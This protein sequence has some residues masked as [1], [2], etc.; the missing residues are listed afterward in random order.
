MAQRFVGKVVVVTGA[1]SGIG[2]AAAQQFARAGAT[3]A[4][5]ARTTDTL[6]RVAAEIAASGGTARAFPT[7]VSVP[8]ACAALLRSIAE[9]FGGIDILV[10]NAGANKRGAVEHRE[11]NDLINIVRVNLIAPIVL[12]R[13]ALPYLRQRGGGAIVNVASI[14]GQ[15]PLPEEA[16][17]SATKFGLRA[18]SFALREELAGSKITV[19]AVSPGPVDTAF[20]MSEI[21]EVPNLVFANPMSSADDVA[22]LILDCAAD[23]RRERTIPLMTGIMA[24]VGNLVPALRRALVPVLEKRGRVA[25]DKYIARRRAAAK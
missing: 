15:I 1:S 2:A 12:T 21:D 10:N 4:V 14:A 24:R 11:V 8:T 3:V 17:Y 19:S 6:E 18:F 13:L 7:D 20:I 22:R 9:A 16:T 23:G 25:K 5:V